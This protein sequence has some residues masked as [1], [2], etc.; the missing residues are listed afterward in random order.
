MGLESPS[1][2]HQPMADSVAAPGNSRP[3]SPAW[4]PVYTIA[5]EVQPASL[6]DVRIVIHSDIPRIIHLKDRSTGLEL[7][8]ALTIA[9]HGDHEGNLDIT[10]DSNNY[11]FPQPIWLELIRVTDQWLEKYLPTETWL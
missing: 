11:T 9:H 10:I 5:G 2:N 6:D 3:S 7:C 4:A 8:R 1:V